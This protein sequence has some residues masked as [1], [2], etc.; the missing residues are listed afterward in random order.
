M[1]P[2]TAFPSPNLKGTQT[3]TTP[4]FMLTIGTKAKEYRS[5]VKSSPCQPENL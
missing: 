1:A 3:H 5:S 2:F 4:I